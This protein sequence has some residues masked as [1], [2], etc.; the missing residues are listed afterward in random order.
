MLCP[1]LA[2]ESSQ[3]FQAFGGHSRSVYLKGVMYSMESSSARVCMKVL[4]YM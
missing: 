3:Q 1:L 2:A 4:F